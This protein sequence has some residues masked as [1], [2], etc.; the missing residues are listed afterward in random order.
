[1]K[2]KFPVSRLSLSRIALPSAVACSALLFFSSCGGDGDVEDP[3]ASR[4]KIEMKTS[5]GIIK[6][7]LF[8]KRAPVTVKNFVSYAKKGHY[9]GTIFHR[10]IS[11]MVVQGGGFEPDEKGVLIEKPTDPPIINEGLTNGLKNIAG[12]ISMARTSDLHSATSQFFLNFKDNPGWDS[13][14]SPYT[15]FGK[16]TDGMDVIHRI[17]QVKTGTRKARSRGGPDDALLPESPMR[18][19]PVVDVV[20]ESVRVLNN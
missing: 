17:K 8:D 3:S 10:V 15:V 7:E 6:L 1:M 19:V 12:A 9:D 16:I 5:M 20:I 2:M 4:T 13:E 14:R 11:S 18:D